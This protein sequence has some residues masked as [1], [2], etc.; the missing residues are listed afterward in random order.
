MTQETLTHTMQ[1]F[2]DTIKQ[3]KLFPQI[4]DPEQR[5]KEANDAVKLIEGQYKPISFHSTIRLAKNVAITAYAAG[6]VEG[7]A[8]FL[9]NLN[10]YQILYTG[11]YSME[12]DKTLRRAEIPENEH[13]DVLIT[14]GTYGTLSHVDRAERE[15]KLLDYCETTLKQKGKVLFPVFAQGRVIELL[16]ILNDHWAVNPDLQ[17]Y[18]ITFITQQRIK[19]PNPLPYVSIEPKNNIDKNQ[20]QIVF[21]T[22]G[23]LQSGVSRELF[24]DMCD[25]DKNALLVTGYGSNG[26]LLHQVIQQYKNP[27]K[28]ILKLQKSVGGMIKL[29]MRVLELSFSA[30]SDFTQICELLNKTRPD[31]IIFVHGSRGA[32]GNLIKQ[33][34]L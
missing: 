28:D 16:Q 29:R 18:K 11:D 8:M 34:N 1:N 14:E 20:P 21:C 30:H 13:I 5:D 32:L 33:L 26:S 15:R 31:N 6:H 24:E 2:R 25:S 3:K 17:Q 12:Q 7:A 4:R 19:P 22:P 9:I 23:M 27:N 10:N